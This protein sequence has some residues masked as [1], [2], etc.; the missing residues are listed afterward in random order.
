MYPFSIANFYIKNTLSHIITVKF[1]SK[2]DLA[3]YI[4]EQ[5]FICCKL[6]RVGT[7]IK[8]RA[9]TLLEHGQQNTIQTSKS[10]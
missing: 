1:M 5:N 6:K 4:L 7:L 2:S 8:I 10:R 9:H 3:V